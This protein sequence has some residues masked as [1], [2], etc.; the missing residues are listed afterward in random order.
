MPE[1]PG[2]YAPTNGI[3]LWYREEGD[4]GGEPLLLIMGLNSQLILW[5][6]ELVRELGERRYRVIRF[7]NR[8]CGRSDKIAATVPPGGGPAYHL[9][10]LAADTVGLLDHLGIER[11]HVVGASMGGMVA[12][13]IAIHHPERAATLTSIMS[14][15]GNPLVG[16]PTPEAVAAVQEPTPTEREA[17]IDHITNV[18]TV[19]GSRT[20][21]E[22]EHPRR[23]QFAADSFDR[24]LHPRGAQRQFAAILSAVDRTPRLR[25]LDL[26]TAVVHGAEDAL[27]D[28]SGGRTTHELVSGSTYREFPDMGHDLPAV[29]LPELVDIIDANARTRSALSTQ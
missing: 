29:L 24:G 11:A 9:V 20:H 12:Q 7:D 8:D 17:A 10:D 28:V 26:P 18:Y 1:E 13:L 5:P 21:A 16:Y 3:R 25:E 19:I 22:A 15:T 27:I 23:R 6:D 2:A 14:T 4:P